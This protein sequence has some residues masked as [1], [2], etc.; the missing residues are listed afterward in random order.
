MKTPLDPSEPM[1]PI[2]PNEPV[3]Q[4]YMKHGTCKFAQSCKFHHPPQAPV[5]ATLMNGGAVVMN[6]PT[7][8]ND[9]TRIVLNQGAVDANGR[10]DCATRYEWHRIVVDA[11]YSISCEC[12][13]FS[14]RTFSYAVRVKLFIAYRIAR[15]G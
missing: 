13:T 2:R 10:A 6:V 9:A 4:Y 7:R 14:L 12:G 5:Q 1:F 11:Q 8:K 15:F 3:C